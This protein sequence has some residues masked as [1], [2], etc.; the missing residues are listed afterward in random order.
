MYGNGANG[1]VHSILPGDSGDDEE[2]QVQHPPPLTPLQWMY[3]TVLN[4]R[5]FGKTYLWYFD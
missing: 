2:E 4:S 5:F 3:V 1:G